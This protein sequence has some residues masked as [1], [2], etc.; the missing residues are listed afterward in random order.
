MKYKLG[1]TSRELYTTYATEDY[2]DDEEIDVR[3]LP[4]LKA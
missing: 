1:S 2:N 4:N 3:Q